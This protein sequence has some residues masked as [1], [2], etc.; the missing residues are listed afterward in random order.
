[1]RSIGEMIADNIRAERN[2]KG[3]TQEQIAEMLGMA[4]KTYLEYEKDAKNIKAGNLYKLAAI[5]GC[6]V[7]DFFIQ[8]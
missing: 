2:R 1:M 8:R 6:K 7:D 5:L 3:Y 4:T